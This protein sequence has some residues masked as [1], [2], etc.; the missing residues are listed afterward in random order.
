MPPLPSVGHDHDERE[1][2]VVFRKHELITNEL[3]QEMDA[4][5][6]KKLEEDTK[7]YDF[8]AE[9]VKISTLQVGAVLGCSTSV[10][11]GCRTR[12]QC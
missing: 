6:D 4:M 11:L 12:L 7:A 2:F 1:L 8:T 5:E 10:I 9:L 3:A